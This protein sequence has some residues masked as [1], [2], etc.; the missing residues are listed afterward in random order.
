MH[1]L[2]ESLSALQLQLH[3]LLLV[4]L[5]QAS[6]PAATPNIDKAQPL[7][8]SPGV[9]RLPRQDQTPLWYDFWLLRPVRANW[10]RSGLG[11]AGIF[12]TDHAN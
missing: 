9:A 7:P 5:Q 8:Q 2:F 3:L 4:L 1:A 12:V 10:A 6:G 11:S